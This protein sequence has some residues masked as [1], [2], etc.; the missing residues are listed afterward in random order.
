MPRCSSS[1]KRRPAQAADEQHA[2]ET[3]E[4]ENKLREL[5]AKRRPSWRRK[6]GPQPKPAASERARSSKRTNRTAIAIRWTPSLSVSWPQSRARSRR[7]RLRRRPNKPRSSK[8]EQ[9]QQAFQQAERLV[10]QRRARDAD[11]VLQALLAAIDD[12]PAD[13]QAQLPAS[14]SLQR[15]RAQVAQRAAQVASTPRPRAKAHR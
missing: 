10:Q 14:F 11:Q 9:L 7:T 1:W 13:V 2:Q 6:T 15:F 4:A 5:L 8:V 12:V 3:R